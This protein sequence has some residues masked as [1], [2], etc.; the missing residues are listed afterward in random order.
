MLEYADNLTQHKKNK[1]KNMSQYESSSNLM[2]N[3]ASRKDITENILKINHDHSDSG[4]VTDQETH[5]NERY[6]RKKYLYWMRSWLFL[7]K[8]SIKS[9]PGHFPEDW[10][11]W[12]VDHEESSMNISLLWIFEYLIN[13]SLML[14][15]L[16][17]NL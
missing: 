11:W 10:I 13:I 4:L 16:H 17:S 2:D 6:N 1:P 7:E 3:Y 5:T 8:F 15:F 12:V 14:I 9:V